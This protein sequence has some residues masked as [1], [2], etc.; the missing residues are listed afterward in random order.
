MGGP[1]RRVSGNSKCPKKHADLTKSLSKCY[2]TIYLTTDATF[3]EYRSSETILSR[4]FEFA[5]TSKPEL[6]RLD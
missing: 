6:L 3:V 5:S 1:V 4:N 2:L